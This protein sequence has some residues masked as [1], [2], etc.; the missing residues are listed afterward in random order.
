MQQCPVSS[1]SKSTARWAMASSVS[2]SAIRFF[3][4]ASSPVSGCQA[5]L[6]AAVDPVLAAPVV[7]RLLADVEVVR[8]TGD[9]SS[10]RE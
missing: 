8:D 5:S 4:A 3:A 2:S 7:N 1:L 10:L 9:A 6:K